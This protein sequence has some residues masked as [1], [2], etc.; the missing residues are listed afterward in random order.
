[1]GRTYLSLKLEEAV[2]IAL[3]QPVLHDAVFL[4]F[5]LGVELRCLG[6]NFARSGEKL[7]PVEFQKSVQSSRPRL[8][9]LCA[10]YRA[11]STRLRAFLE[12]FLTDVGLEQVL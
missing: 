12:L 9:F 1:M 5:A 3:K 11:L 6:A 8:R 4:I 10:S 2:K 7:V